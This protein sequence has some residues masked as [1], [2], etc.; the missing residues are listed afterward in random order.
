MQRMRERSP[1]CP[2]NLAGKRGGL[3]VVAACADAVALIRVW[4]ARPG[5][6]GARVCLGRDRCSGHLADIEEN[7]GAGAIRARARQGKRDGRV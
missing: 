1:Q 7:P 4:S 6:P 5:L 3:A 2:G